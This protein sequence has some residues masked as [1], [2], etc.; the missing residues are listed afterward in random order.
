MTL[1][2]IVNRHNVFCTSKSWGHHLPCRW[3]SLEQVRRGIYTTWIVSL[4]PIQS[5]DTNTHCEL[6]NVRENWLGLSETTSDFP[7]L[8]IRCQKTWHPQNR[9]FCHAKFIAQNIL[10]SL[11]VS[12]NSIGYLIYSH[13]FFTMWW[14]GSIFSLVMEV[15]G[16]PNLGLD[17]KPFLPLLNSVAYFCNVNKVGMSPLS[18]TTM[19]ALRSWRIKPFL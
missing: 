11:T 7:A 18:I 14:T 8:F 16:H 10:N 3:L 13:S 4:Y 17:S 12:E 19:L 15:T 9:N 1:L 6:R 5:D 2:K